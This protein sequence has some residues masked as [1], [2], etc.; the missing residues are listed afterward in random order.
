VPEFDRRAFL[1]RPPYVRTRDERAGESGYEERDAEALPAGGREGL[2]PSFH[3]RADEHYVDY[4]TSAGSVPLVQLVAVRDID[5]A[6]PIGAI[7]LGPLVESV[8]S[9]GVIQPLLVRR[10]L[11]RYE[12]ITGSKRLAAAI[13]AGLTEVPCLLQEVDDARAQELA[14]AENLRFDRE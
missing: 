10:R 8:A 4:I 3:M 11:G 1:P 2:P 7:D 5:G 14:D 13:A 6:R 12:L 9:L